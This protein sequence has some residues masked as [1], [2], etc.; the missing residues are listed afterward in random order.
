MAL[1]IEGERIVEDRFVAVRGWIQQDNSVSGRDCLAADRRVG[2]CRS[3]KI[4]ER[5]DPAQHFF[6]CAR[7]QFRILGK[8]LPL[9]LMVAKGP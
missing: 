5:S 9:V 2:C 3:K 7:D 6:D 8:E 4:V 1:Y